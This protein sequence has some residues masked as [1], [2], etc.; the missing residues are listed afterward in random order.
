MKARARALDARA[1]HFARQAKSASPWASQPVVTGSPPGLHVNVELA[2]Q[3]LDTA[4][5]SVG[6]LVLAV[7]Q[8]D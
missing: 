4:A 7:A 6:H 8:P 5:N 3:Q 1:V 2:L